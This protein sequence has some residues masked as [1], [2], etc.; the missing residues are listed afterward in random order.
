MRLWRMAKPSAPVILFCF[1]IVKVYLP[2]SI[3][4]DMGKFLMLIAVVQHGVKD[5]FDANLF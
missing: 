5:L 2:M 4:F 1:I 3:G